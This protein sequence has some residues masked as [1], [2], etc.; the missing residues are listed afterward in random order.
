MSTFRNLFLEVLPLCGSNPAA[1]MIKELILGGKLTDM[2]ARRAI[3][4][5]PFYLRLPSEK[6]LAAYEDLLKENTNIKTK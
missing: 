2:E 4:F 5:I 1:L 6:L 3:T